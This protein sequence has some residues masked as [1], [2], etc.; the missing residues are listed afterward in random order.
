MK[1]FF[2][3]IIISLLI[4]YTCILPVAAA[5]P[6]IVI[7]GGA[8]AGGGVAG[9]TNAKGDLA[10]LLA[11]LVLASQGVSVGLKSNSTF[12]PIDFVKS[13]LEDYASLAGETFD[14]ICD[15]WLSNVKILANGAI[16]M[17]MESCKSAYQF[18]SWLKNDGYISANLGDRDYVS[19][20]G[21]LCPVIHP[22]DILDTYYTSSGQYAVQNYNNFDI[23]VFWSI[24]NGVNQTF[25]LT[26]NSADIKVILYYNGYPI[27]G[28]PSTVTTYYLN[29]LYYGYSTN[30]PDITYNIPYVDN[31][32]QSIT[33]LDGS[34]DNSPSSPDN[35]TLIGD[36]SNVDPDDF[37][38]SDNQVNIIS[39]GIDLAALA[40]QAGK[41]GIV[42][43]KN[44][45][46]T[47]LNAVNGVDDNV[48]KVNDSVTGILE[49][50]PLPGYD[51][52]NSTSVASDDESNVTGGSVIIDN[53]KYPDA[54]STQ[55]YI[56][57]MQF[58]LVNVF[59]FC[60]PFDIVNLL[61]KLDVQP[62]TPHVNLSFPNPVLNEP[63]EFDLDFSQWNGVA[64][65]VRN[66]EL[67]AFV[68]GLAM[69]TRN[70]I[71]G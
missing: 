61:S 46:E 7:D 35:D 69:V 21:V 10:A 6:S 36:D 29:G 20:N 71:R 23:V 52:V 59:P 9:G 63:I 53:N 11:S 33:N 4:C 28:R 8:V 42:Q 26:K 15:L 24:Y 13:L 41:S 49:D 57:H 55:K 31:P 40:V 62:V 32:I 18:L 19:I 48:L 44:Y 1:K 45:L 17:G 5:T 14:S 30:N 60:I 39:P 67:V 22:N 43:I 25:Y 58:N 70:L 47:L 66:A 27:T 3:I 16:S 38:I 56:K 50:L 34:L 37:N 65:V 2:S 54:E 51:I 68:V 12:L 64:Q